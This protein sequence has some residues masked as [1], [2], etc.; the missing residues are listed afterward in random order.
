MALTRYAAN[1]LWWFLHDLLIH[2]LTGA[3]G[4]LGRLCGS[5]RLMALSHHIH[6]VTAPSNDALAD[7]AE[8]AY[9]A[10][11]NETPGNPLGSSTPDEQDYNRERARKASGKRPG[12]WIDD[13]EVHQILKSNGIEPWSNQASGGRPEGEEYEAKPREAIIAE[14]EQRKRHLERITKALEE[15]DVEC[16]SPQTRHV[17]R[18]ILRRHGLGK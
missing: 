13:K 11:C 15:F 14:L 12:T 7:Y 6:N 18:K 1:S 17:L 4:L 8:A 5:Y 9:R 10:G 2:P 3:I 16:E